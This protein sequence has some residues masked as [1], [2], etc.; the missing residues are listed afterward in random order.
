MDPLQPIVLPVVQ[1]GLPPYPAAQV[2][3]KI[4]RRVAVSLCRHAGSESG[5]VASVASVRQ[6]DVGIVFEITIIDEAG[7]VDISN[8][9]TRLMVFG[10]PVVGWFTRQAE[11]VT[12][13]TD[14]KIQYKTIPGDLDKAGEWR[15]Q[16]K[17]ALPTFVDT[18]YTEMARF[19]VE[20]IIE[21]MNT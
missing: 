8:S 19:T 17:I 21:E 3:L 11:F 1:F 18:F 7:A 20:P 10:K 5:Q 4:C 6:N 2:V 14:G 9:A 16:A 15:L 12:D 13:G